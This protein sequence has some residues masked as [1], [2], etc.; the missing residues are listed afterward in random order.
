MVIML[1]GAGIL[2]VTILGFLCTYLFLLALAS[3]TWYSRALLG[4]AIIG[5]LFFGVGIMLSGYQMIVPYL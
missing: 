4:M 5:I 1:I 2:I 3:K